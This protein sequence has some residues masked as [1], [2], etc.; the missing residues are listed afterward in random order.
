MRIAIMGTGGIGGYCGAK[1]ATK[2]ADILFIARGEHLKAMQGSGLRLLSALGN[3]ALQEVNATD[4]PA[5]HA[6]TDF[7]LF[8][9][10]GPDTDNAIELIA[11]I[12]RHQTGI[13]SFQN[14]VDGIDK[15]AAKY[16]KATVLPGAAMTNCHIERPG[17]IRHFGKSNS[18]TFGEWN[19]ELSIRASAYRNLAQIAGIHTEVSTTPLV[20]VWTKYVRA[21]AGMAVTCLSRLPLKTCIE[22]PET[23]ELLVQAMREG[24]SLA[25]ALGIEVPM[26]TID[27]VLAAGATMDPSWKTSMLT[28]IEASKVIEAESIFGAAH[29]MG[30]DLGQPTPLLSVAYRALKHYARRER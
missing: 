5:G 23:R 8:T 6:P 1:L 2:G 15:L 9:V 25:R 12:V 10:K 29:R 16:G 4:N 28:D 21:A 26:E 14:G 22:T 24:I 19:G 18:F 7:V 3:V 20:D 17:V 27:R 13:I 11:P 30:Q